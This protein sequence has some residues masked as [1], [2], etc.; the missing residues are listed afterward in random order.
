LLINGNE[1]NTNNLQE[2]RVDNYKLNPGSNEI[3]IIAESYY[4]SKTNQIK[5]TV[6]S[7]VEESEEEMEETEQEEGEEISEEEQV[8]SMNI[9]LSVINEDAWIVATVDGITKVNDTVQPGNEFSFTATEE[10]TIYSPR[11]QMVSLFIN[12][13]QY[14][15]SSQV[16][17]SF[18]LADGSI[19]QE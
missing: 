15:F 11:P 16:T 14:T 1:V 5:L 8:E 17:T 9:K 12:G 6:V 2:F 4:F 18:K 7:Q 13:E 3:Y 19:V 10:F